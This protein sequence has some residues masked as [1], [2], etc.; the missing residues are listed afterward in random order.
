MNNLN[1]GY[2]RFPT[3]PEFDVLRKM[4]RTYGRI[5]KI[6]ELFYP[7]NLVNPVEKIKTPN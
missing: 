5:N 7:V 1:S 3:K 4:D 6:F 2:P